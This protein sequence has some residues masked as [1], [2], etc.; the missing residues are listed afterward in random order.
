MGQKEL[1]LTMG[2]AKRSVVSTSRSELELSLVC[3]PVQ[4]TATAVAKCPLILLM[5]V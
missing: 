5:Q 4:L 3:S 1:R 2:M